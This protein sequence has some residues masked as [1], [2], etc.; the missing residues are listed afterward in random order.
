MSRD[1]KDWAGNIAA[2]IVVLVVN[3]MANGIPI[4]GQTTG[5]ISA[6]YP[7]LFTPDGFTFSIWGLIY[8]SLA[9]FVVYQALPAQRDNAAIAGIGIWFKLNCLANA[10]WIFAWH[11]DLL[12]VSLL[13]MLGILGTLIQIFRS[14]DASSILLVRFPFSLYTGWITVATIANISVLQT[15]W[16]L[17]DA[18]LTAVQWTWVKLAVA[19][20]I[21]AVVIGRTRNTIYLAV[22]AWAA[23]GIY[24]KQTDTP[25]VVGAAITL[26]L[27]ALLLMVYT[28]LFN[29]KVTR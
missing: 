18:G 16:G 10:L 15:A 5:E 28:T 29:R 2:F 12:I 21:G 22:I 4:G 1:L 23:F 7:S 3:G 13:L 19:G 26:S 17:N 25:E 20:A 14:I 8:L 6:K 11:Y 9:V 27:L 24:S